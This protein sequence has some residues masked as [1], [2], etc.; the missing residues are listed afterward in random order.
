MEAI[1]IESVENMES[2]VKLRGGED[3][4]YDPA[5]AKEL[6]EQKCSQCH[7]HNQVE[8][9]P[10]ATRIDAIAL[11]QRMVGN[12]LTASES[13][14]N[15]II[16]H[17]ARTYATKPLQ[18]GQLPSGGDESVDSQLARNSQKVIEGMET[19]ASRH[20]IDCHGPAGKHPVQSNFPVL[21]GQ[22]EEYLIRQFKDI[23][24]GTRSNSV[25]AIMRAIVQDVTDQEIALIAGY[26]SSQ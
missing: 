10:P 9:S 23:R 25:T 19:Y 21:A 15:V 14:L 4:K 7:S 12:G 6:F 20:C 11:V 5:S 3:Y 2:I 22:R 18:I 17:L 26:L 16:Q 13:E 8:Q 1:S 24:D